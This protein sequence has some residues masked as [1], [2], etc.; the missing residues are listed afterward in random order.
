MASGAVYPGQTST[1]GATSE[2]GIN[3]GVG[4][5][6]VTVEGTSSS[7]LPA[8]VLAIERVY[9]TYLYDLSGLDDYLNQSWVPPLAEVT[10]TSLGEATVRAAAAILHAKEH[11]V[12]TLKDDKVVVKITG[13]SSASLVDCQ[14]EKDFYLV[15]NKTGIPDPAVSR[16]DFV[17]VAQLVNHNGRWYVS[18]FAT[19]H[20]VCSY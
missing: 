9:E 17:G 19:T 11:G 2:T 10:T 16:N 12:G 1:K 18:V 4:G 7:T 20:T 3:H 15:E 6:Q 8:L 5:P 14:N 13:P